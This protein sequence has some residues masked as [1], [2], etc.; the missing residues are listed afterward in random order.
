MDLMGGGGGCWGVKGIPPHPRI[1]EAIVHPIPTFSHPISASAE[2][3]P[4]RSN[5]V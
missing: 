2:D 1:S 3:S 5:F 4:L